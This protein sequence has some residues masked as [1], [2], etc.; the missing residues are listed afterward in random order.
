VSVAAGVAAPE[1]F[2]VAAVPD[3]L[4]SEAEVWA[5]ANPATRMKTAVAVISLMQFSPVNA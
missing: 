1:L 3:G 5:Q 4:T 2:C